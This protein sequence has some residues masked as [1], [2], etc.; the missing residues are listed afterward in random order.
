MDPNDKDDNSNGSNDT[1]M[2]DELEPSSSPPPYPLSS[3]PNPNAQE[4]TMSEILL[5]TTYQPISDPSEA[6]TLGSSGAGAEADTSRVDHG[7]P[8]E[9]WNN[10]Q[11]SEDCNK[12]ETLLSDRNWTPKYGDPLR[13]LGAKSQD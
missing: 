9:K 7:K 5:D 1:E 2:L 12:A 6:K 11:W 10:P 13:P 4:T 3:L 8:G